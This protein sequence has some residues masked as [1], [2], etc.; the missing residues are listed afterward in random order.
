MRDR[1]RIALLVMAGAAVALVAGAIGL[2]K[3]KEPAPGQAGVT[4][5][6]RSSSTAACKGV[7]QGELPRLTGLSNTRAQDSINADI[8]S[9]LCTW[10]QQ[11]MR[12][13]DRE[14]SG[15]TGFS[16][17]YRV[18]YLDKH[19]VSIQVQTGTISRKQAHP[20]EHALTLNY[21]LADGARIER[22]KLFYPYDLTLDNLL[23]VASSPPRYAEWVNLTRSDTVEVDTFL[24]DNR[25][26]VFVFDPCRLDACAAGYV[27][28]PV[29]Y[30]NLTGLIDPQGAAAPYL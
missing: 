28:L 26:V 27:S 16:M 3:P 10:A 11:E 9:S 30:A 17:A 15:L 8:E 5:Q 21:L 18:H 13:D 24:I 12:L 4:V 22:S 7:L 29:P 23:T 6:G 14:N 19:L 20:A 1:R 25:G 2:A